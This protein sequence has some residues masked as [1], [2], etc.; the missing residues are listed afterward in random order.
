V[1]LKTNKPHANA[2][3]SIHVRFIQDLGDLVYE[4]GSVSIVL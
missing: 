2:Q 1:Y 3:G 4:I